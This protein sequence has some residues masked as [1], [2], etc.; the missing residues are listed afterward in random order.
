MYE[1]YRIALSVAQKPI[2][3]T[4]L[5]RLL[6]LGDKIWSETNLQEVVQDWMF[7]RKFGD[8]S[9]ENEVKFILQSLVTESFC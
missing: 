7:Q 1:L 9:M 6:A 8:I 2:D 3:A 5:R 4:F